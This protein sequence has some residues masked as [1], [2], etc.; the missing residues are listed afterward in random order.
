MTLQK[1]EVDSLE[2]IE[3]IFLA[4]PSGVAMIMFLLF[5][6]GIRVIDLGLIFALKT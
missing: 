2:G 3:A 1:Q 6:K 4:L 5:A